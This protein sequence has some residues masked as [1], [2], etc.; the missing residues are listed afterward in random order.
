MPRTAKPTTTRAKTFRVEIANY[1]HVMKEANRRGLPWATVLNQELEF[2][3]TGALV[4]SLLARFMVTVDAHRNTFRDELKTIMWNAAMY[5]PRG[6]ALSKTTIKREH[7]LH[8]TSANI[9][10]ANLAYLNGRST[11]THQDFTAVLN[12]ELLF[13]RTFELTPEL[14]GRVE[15]H[16][17]KEEITVREW[18]TLEVLKVAFPLLQ[19]P[20]KTPKSHTG[21]GEPKTSR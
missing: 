5:L 10:G 3:R 9:T 6:A 16:L 4:S 13:A 2:L 14:L 20:L 8:E 12:Q 17:A 15:T 11:G 1:D 21:D 7:P 19:Y 18:S